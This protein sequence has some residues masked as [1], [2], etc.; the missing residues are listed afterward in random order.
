MSACV[1]VCA[2]SSSTLWCF[3][4][5]LLEKAFGGC[6][7]GSE[8]YG[9]TAERSADFSVLPY[10]LLSLLQELLEKALQGIVRQLREGQDS[11]RDVRRL[12]QQQASVEKELSRVTQE[13]AEASKVGRLLVAVFLFQ[14]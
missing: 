3:A 8:R 9:T 6:C 1:C 13:L 4:M 14:K 10:M 5:E 2:V 11:P 12:Q 7:V